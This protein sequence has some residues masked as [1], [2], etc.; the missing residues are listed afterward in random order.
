MAWQNA[1]ASTIAAKITLLSE[2]CIF[3]VW[4]AAEARATSISCPES[5]AEMVASLVQV[6]AP[7]M[8]N[9]RQLQWKP[10]YSFVFEAKLNSPSIVSM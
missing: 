4:N 6:L 8:D 5:L 9:L 1:D 7:L 2:N 3:S 10:I